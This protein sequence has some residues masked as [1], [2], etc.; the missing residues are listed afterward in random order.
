MYFGN[1]TK[2]VW[3][4]V[5]ADICLTTPVYNKNMPRV[6]AKHELITQFLEMLAREDEEQVQEKML[7][8]FEQFS[9]TFG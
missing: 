1:F 3:E 2:F 6:S 8:Q 4:Y 7:E 5:V 9:T